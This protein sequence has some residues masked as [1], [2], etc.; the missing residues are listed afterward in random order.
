MT[1]GIRIYFGPDKPL[2]RRHREDDPT[3]SMLEAAAAWDSLAAELQNTST[4]YQNV[5]SQ[6]TS[7]P[8]QGPTS[9]GMNA[10]AQPYIQ[11]LEQHALP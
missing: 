10:A 3:G 9:S 5:I 1:A 6:L 7:G 11:W 2:I 4:Q 8:W